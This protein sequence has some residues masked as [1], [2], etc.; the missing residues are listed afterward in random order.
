[1]E[2]TRAWLKNFLRP[3]PYSLY[4]AGA[5]VL[6]GIIFSIT[7]SNW[8]IVLFCAGI[9]ASISCISGY[10]Y[11]KWNRFTTSLDDETLAEIIK[12]RDSVVWYV[13]NL[14]MGE[15]YIFGKHGL[16]VH[17]YSEIKRV[18][19]YVRRVSGGIDKKEIR[20]ETKSGTYTLCDL[21]IETTTKDDIA[22]VFVKIK[23]KN[24]SVII[25][26]YW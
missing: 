12:D 1:M 15:K 4:L 17:E 10:D 7:L 18:Y 9:V 13:P 6:G 5:F 8:M 24:P 21:D 19:Q 14:A 26:Y 22:L 20:V 3:K 23:T 25:G 2:E 16:I 11:L